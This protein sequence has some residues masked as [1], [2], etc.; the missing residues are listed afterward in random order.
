MILSGTAIS[1]GLGMG[2][3]IRV[4]DILHQAESRELI[5]VEG[6]DSE[7]KRIEV[8]FANTRQELAESVRRLEEQVGPRV[9]DIFR[10]HEM[11]LDNFLSSGEIRTEMK[12]ARLDPGTAVRRVFRRWIDNFRSLKDISMRQRADD[13]ADLGR[14]LLRHL[15]PRDSDR[16]TD[17]P[18]GC[19]LIFK[20]LLP[21]DVVALPNHDIAAIVVESLGQASHAA[22]LVREKNIPTVAG[23]AGV[24]ERVREGEEVLVDGYI[25][26]IVIAPDPAT[27]T[28][29]EARLDQ[30][31]STQ[32][33]CRGACREPAHTLDGTLVKV[34][35]NLGA[36]DNIELALENGADGVGLFRIEQLYLTQELPPTEDE[37][38]TALD[39]IAGRLDG[40]PLTVR[41]LDVGG[42][43]PMPFLH[44]PPEANPGLG[45]RG[46]RIL[47]EHPGLMRPQLAALARLSERYPVRILVPMVT[48]EEDV[49]TIR[50]VFET[51]CAAC[52]VKT[53][54]PFGAMIETPAAALGVPAI[55]KHVDF[56]CVGTN[57]LT[58]Y[59]FAAGRD[60]PAVNRYF[61][62]THHALMRLLEIIVADAGDL[63]VTLCGELAGRE[64][65]TPQLLGIGFRALSVSP[66][67]IPAL[68]ARVR[69][70]RVGA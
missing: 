62:D 19:V 9:A 29:F 57:D 4:G 42:D 51:M 16:L 13:I 33:R 47:L 69:S 24:H 66:P 52:G 32:M 31:Q 55:A 46:A 18:A 48:L 58:Q 20:R 6:F 54:P 2:P 23:F 35:A 30:Y 37:L 44:L 7:W 25:G 65:M 43:K 68:K 26:E 36:N 3:A 64:A 27:R 10:A 21:S 22:L 60:D 70:L 11:M 49:R 50:E 67:T 45:M 63:P 17:L 1:S 5:A 15:E 28:E 40:K 56:L 41:L 14:R 8:A 39:R 34:E 38:L 59:T 53:P 61:Q 12:E